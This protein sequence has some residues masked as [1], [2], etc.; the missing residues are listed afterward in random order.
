MAG[1]GFFFA[2]VLAVVH[3]KLK[4]KEDPRVESISELL[5]GSNCG[6][7]GFTGCRHY[8]VALAKGGVSPDQCKALGEDALRALSNILG[9]KIEKKI[10][11]IAIIRCGADGTKR[12]KKARYTGVKTCVAAD[13]MLAGEILCKYGCLGYGDCVKACPF[14]AIELVAGLPAIDGNK[15][16]ACGK[17]VP[18]CP[19]GII[20]LAKVNSEN[21]IYVACMNRDRCP[22][23]RKAC[24][25]GCVACGI[26]QK[27]TGGVLALENNLADTDYD[28]LGN[29]GNTEEVVN[30]C[31]TKCIRG[32]KR[33]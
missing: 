21:F 23:T 6:A 3:Q 22:E 28:R 33:R 32:I 4:V 12:K 9:V 24:S 7:C 16:T 14:E 2:S 8:A 20:T 11:E 15:C 30:K 31:P 27:L 5:P 25:V 19:R 13:Q 26:C 1:L 10:K 17:C 29:I 18:A